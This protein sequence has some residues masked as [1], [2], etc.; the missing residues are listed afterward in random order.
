MSGNT[1]M[2]EENNTSIVHIPKNP[3]RA[4]G[5][6]LRGA[7]QVKGRFCS[8]PTTGICFSKVTLAAPPAG[9]VIPPSRSAG[10]EDGCSGHL[11]QRVWLPVPP[12]LGFSRS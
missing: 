2:M 4:E 11:L 7:Q 1:G 8:F 9:A 6:G 5:M 3:S 10:G 12:S